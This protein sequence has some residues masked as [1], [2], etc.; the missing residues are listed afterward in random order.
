MAIFGPVDRASVPPLTQFYQLKV[1]PENLIGGEL[2]RWLFSF[3]RRHLPDADARACDGLYSG[4]E[5]G[6]ADA[7]TLRALADLHPLLVR[8]LDAI[9]D[10]TFPAPDDQRAINQKIAQGLGPTQLAWL[11]IGPAEKE[12][13]TRSLMV[14]SGFVRANVPTF[15][16][17]LLQNFVA[18]AARPDA[19]RRCEACRS[20]FERT[21][22]G[23]SF[24]SSRCSGRDRNR[25]LRKQNQKDAPKVLH[26][27]HQVG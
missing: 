10:D 18:A 20:V 24:C 15:V 13:R 25:R 5:H 11:P 1:D 17:L 16:S 22:A 8:I 12:Q 26:L 23:Q 9:A 4:E 2:D 14:L 6:G 7:D 19:L 21:R 3:T 27:A